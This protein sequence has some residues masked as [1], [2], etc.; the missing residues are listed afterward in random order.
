[1]VQIGAETVYEQNT[2]VFWGSG[3]IRGPKKVDPYYC[4][5]EVWY[6]IVL[7]SVPKIFCTCTS[8]VLTFDCQMETVSVCTVEEST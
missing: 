3:V 7:L 8:E 4:R 1:M 6:V 5:T 2:V